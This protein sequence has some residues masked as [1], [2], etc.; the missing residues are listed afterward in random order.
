MPNHLIWLLFFYTFFH[1]GLNIIAEVLRFADR[2]FY[3]DWWWVC[4]CCFHFAKVIIKVFLNFGG[5]FL[6]FIYNFW[7]S[8]VK[9]QNCFDIVRISQRN[10]SPHRQPKFSMKPHVLMIELSYW[11]WAACGHQSRLGLASHADALR[12]SLGRIAWRAK[13]MLRGRLGWTCPQCGWN[14]SYVKV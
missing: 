12:A 9:L 13:R 11:A 10:F 5:T 2:T 4:C 1:S 3:R 7:F 6:A 14:W 8:P